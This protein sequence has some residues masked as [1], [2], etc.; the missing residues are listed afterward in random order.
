[1]RQL[2]HAA[3]LPAVFALRQ[4]LVQAAQGIGIASQYQTG[5]RVK[6]GDSLV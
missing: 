2:Q 6:C 5:K 3:G 1:M 4:M